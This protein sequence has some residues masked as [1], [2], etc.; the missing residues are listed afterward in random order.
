MQI[1]AHTDHQVMAFGDHLMRLFDAATGDLIV[2]AT[3][4]DNT[5]TIT[6]E[7]VPDVTAETR[8][9]ALA[10]MPQQAFAALGPSGPGGKGYSTLIPH[11]L[12]DLP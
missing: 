2:E 12:A 1:V 8:A 4:T 9:D 11:G 6:A 3:R 5:W 10:E 7:G